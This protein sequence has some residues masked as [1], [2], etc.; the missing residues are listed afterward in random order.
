MIEKLDSAP[1]LLVLDQEDGGFM[2][3]VGTGGSGVKPAIQCLG[4]FFGLLQ[5][6]KNLCAQQEVITSALSR[7][8]FVQN[9]QRVLGGGGVEDGDGEVQA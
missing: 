2:I 1:I 5:G 6:V 9:L 8:R 3:Q 4:G 7:R